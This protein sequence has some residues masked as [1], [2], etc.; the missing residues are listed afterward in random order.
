MESLRLGGVW[1]VEL[2]GRQNEHG[3]EIYGVALVLPPF[4]LAVPA[5]KELDRV[6]LLKPDLDCY[7]ILSFTARAKQRLP[8]IAGA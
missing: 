1:S 3:V 5:R 2:S 4:H 6:L 7:A 8:P